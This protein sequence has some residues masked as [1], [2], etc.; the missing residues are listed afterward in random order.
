[1]SFY[2]NS[3]G[4]LSKEPLSI[5]TPSYV[6]NVGTKIDNS[7]EYYK[8]LFGHKSF[9]KPKGKN[10][11]GRIEEIDFLPIS[12][13]PFL[14]NHYQN[15]DLP[16]YL[17]AKNRLK[18]TFNQLDF[19]HDPH[20]S[21][22]INQVLLKNPDHSKHLIEL[23]PLDSQDSYKRL[24]NAVL[25][26]RQEKDIIDQEWL[27]KQN[28]QHA[29]GYVLVYSRVLNH[30]FTDAGFR[31]DIPEYKIH[32]IDDFGYG[33]YHVPINSIIDEADLVKSRSNDCLITGQMIPHIYPFRYLLG[34]ILDRCND[35]KT[36]N[37]SDAYRHVQEQIS[38]HLNRTQAGAL[39]LKY[40]NSFSEQVMLDHK[41]RFLNT[42]RD[43][44][45][46]VG[47]SS[48]FGYPLKKYFEF[49][50]N[51]CVVVG[52]MP[53]NKDDLGF[54]HLENVYECQLEEVPD[55]IRMLCKN[56][57]LR[58]RLAKNARNLIMNNYTML[59][60]SNKT[61]EHFNR[62]LSYYK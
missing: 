7:F 49:M 54:K 11:S 56:D 4:S 43:S 46:A 24:I 12:M 20:H 21:L 45:T 17:K 47:C 39:S 61:V 13:Y 3:V 48:V 59:Q 19:R 30:L 42:I 37:L 55:A 1:L 18:L 2:F 58:I 31:A 50:A 27:S 15:V 57:D 38:D 41:K 6:N 22:G 53:I 26:P 33:G 14:Y 34:Q 28:P 9:Q 8:A 25:E 32:F 60:A 35:I 36:I 23:L 62:I 29:D 52:Q 5:H 40:F 10:A 51:G 44:K 16:K